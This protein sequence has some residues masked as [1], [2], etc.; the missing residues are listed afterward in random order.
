MIALVHSDKI[1]SGQ[2]LWLLDLQ[3]ANRNNIRWQWFGIHHRWV[4]ANKRQLSNLL[5]FTV[6]RILSAENLYTDC[7]KSG[8]QLIDSITDSKYYSN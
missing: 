7:I 4:S 1:Y 5:Q 8:Q 6:T 2:W 3:T